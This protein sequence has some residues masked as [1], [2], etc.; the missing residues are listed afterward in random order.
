M[1]VERFPWLGGEICTVCGLPLPDEGRC[2][3][4]AGAVAYQRFTAAF[5]HACDVYARWTLTPAWR[6]LKRRRQRAAAERACDEAD[7]AR[8]LAGFG[9]DEAEGLLEILDATA[10]LRPARWRVD[11]E[12]LR[13]P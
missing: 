1:R 5:E 4:C 9:G 2:H 10:S 12:V 11:Q 13:T 7:I 6:P 3:H 8:D